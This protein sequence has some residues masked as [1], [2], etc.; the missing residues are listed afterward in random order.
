MDRTYLWACP[1]LQI[2]EQHN[3][4]RREDQYEHGDGDEADDRRGP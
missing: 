4:G 3:R 2:E 1:E